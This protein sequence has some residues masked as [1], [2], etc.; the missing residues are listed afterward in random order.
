MPMPMP[1]EDTALAIA[2]HF[3]LLS[4]LL[5]PLQLLFPAQRGQRFWR[6][7]TRTDLIYFVVS[8]FLINAG[9]AALLAL[10]TAL[11]ARLPGALHGRLVAQ[12]MALQVVEI[13]VLAELGGYF[14]H[15]ASHR[16]GW[17]WRFHRIHHS[18]TQLDWLAAHRQ[19]PLEAIWLLGIANMP[20]VVLGFSFESLAWFVLLQK[21]YTAFLHANVH[22]GYGR[23]SLVL[24]SPQFHHWHHDAGGDGEVWSCNFS[25]T[26]PVIDWLFGTYR[27]PGAA[28][29]ARYGLFADASEPPEPVTE[30]VTEGYLG[31]LL[32]PLWPQAAARQNNEAAQR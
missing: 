6:R 25:S 23:L 28:F 20:I 17:L 2:R 12:P 7:G 3:C 8:P 5:T 26:L 10:L 24:A 18:T 16:I 11:A 31:Q 19:H 13:F 21:V 32:Q 22:I 30:P 29:P 15:R 4:A 27:L 9:L 1:I 14:I